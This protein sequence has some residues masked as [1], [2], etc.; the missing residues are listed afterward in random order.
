MFTFETVFEQ[1]E[2]AIFTNIYIYMLC[3]NEM[4]EV[5]RFVFVRICSN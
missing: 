5:I 3:T 2:Q 4:N 1:F